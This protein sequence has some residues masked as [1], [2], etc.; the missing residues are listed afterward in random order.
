MFEKLTENLRMRFGGRARF[1]P[2]RFKDQPGNNPRGHRRVF[3]IP[4]QAGVGCDV[5]TIR[6]INIQFPI[7]NNE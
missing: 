3:P 6:K 5:M 4:R 1:D 2:A 7:S